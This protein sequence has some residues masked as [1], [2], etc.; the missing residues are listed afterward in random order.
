MNL[1][2]EM[3]SRGASACRREYLGKQGI[4]AEAGR[5]RTERGGRKGSSGFVNVGPVWFRKASASG[6]GANSIP[7][8]AD[9]MRAV[10]PKQCPPPHRLQ[11]VWAASSWQP[12]SSRAAAD[13][14]PRVETALSTL[15]SA[16]DRTTLA[17]ETAREI[18]NSV[19]ACEGVSNR[20]RASPSASMIAPK[21]R[22]SRCQIC[23][24]RSS[25]AWLPS[26]SHS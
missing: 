10:Q 13:A 26:S 16:T 6:P 14:K 1:L 25:T 21:A 12:D 18:P 23:Q 3:R 8:A 24:A 17:D 22:W 9:R 2:P 5:Q 15:Q 19:A 4:R 7:G 20:K 11:S